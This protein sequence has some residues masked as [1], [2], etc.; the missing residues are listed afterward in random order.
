MI[1]SSLAHLFKLS[2]FGKVARFGGNYALSWILFP[3]DFGVLA[4]AVAYSQ[5]VLILRASG[6]QAYFVQNYET[7][8]KKLLTT[9]FFADLAMSLILAV[10]IAGIGQVLIVNGLIEGAVRDIM[11]CMGANILISSLSGI[12]FFSLKKKLEFKAFSNTTI[13][14]DLISTGSKIGAAL[15]GFGA[16]SFILG[17]IFGGV[18]KAT[19]A[20]RFVRK[21]VSL[22]CFDRSQTGRIL[23]YIKHTL[24]ISAATYVI[25]NFDKL[26]LYQ[27]AE[28]SELGKYTF[29]FAQLMMLYTFF[30]G[31]INDF[32][33]SVLPKFYGQRDKLN[34]LTISLQVL[35]SVAFIPFFAFLLFNAELLLAAIYSS[36]WEQAEFFMKLFSGQFLAQC[37]VMC[38]MPLLVTQKRPDLSSR[39]KLVKASLI[40]ISTL[41]SY[42]LTGSFIWV[43]YTFAVAS[44]LADFIQATYSSHKYNLDFKSLIGTTLF[45]VVLTLSASF[46]VKN[47]LMGFLSMDRGI[48]DLIL[49][50]LIFMLIYIF[51]VRTLIWR[52]VSSS[53]RFVKKHR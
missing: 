42:N 38:V 6:L 2:V 26:I 14:A 44:V 50:F 4:V 17:E 13:A 41:L 48:P 29:A 30:T 10:I 23:W 46:L 27:I 20:F 34:D 9:V 21:S 18:F 32:L 33:F 35:V 8:E 52:R 15:M 51:V 49:G 12:Y 31:P 11:I 22:D 19:Y 45:V 53:L 47:Y 5:V 43:V 28:L 36:Q 16:L 7:E 24:L 37:T 25:S 3:E 39:F 40:V 1:F